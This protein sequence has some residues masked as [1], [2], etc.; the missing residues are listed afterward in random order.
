MTPKRRILAGL[1]IGMSLLA[2]S[3][4]VAAAG[5]HARRGYGGE[6]DVPGDAA[7]GPRIDD[8]RHTGNFSSSS[9]RFYTGDQVNALPFRSPAEALEIVPG[10]AVGR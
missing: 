4:P 5:R 10:L 2:L 7:P 9:E 3:N 6:R 1:V 8:R